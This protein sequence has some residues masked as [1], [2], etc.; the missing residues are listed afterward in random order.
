M[1]QLDT[2]NLRAAR[3]ME[4]GRLVATLRSPTGAHITLKLRCRKAPEKQGGK[5]LGCT[6]AEATILFIEVP[7][8]GWGDRVARVT[9]SRGFQPDAKAD[10][11]RVWAARALLSWLGG[12]PVAEG[13][14][15]MEEERCG[16]CGRA[17]TD[18]VS[19]ERGIGPECYGAMTGSQ[20]QAKI[21]PEA[22]PTEE[23]QVAVARLSDLELQDERAAGERA[24]AEW[25]NGNE[26]QA[27]QG[28]GRDKKGVAFGHGDFRARQQ[29]VADS[30]KAHAPAKQTKDEAREELFANCSQMN[31]LPGE[32]FADIFQG[33]T[34]RT[35]A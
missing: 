35:R 21:K 3:M 8:D 34:P 22:T 7:S 4:G 2:A 11:K 18:P 14:E 28:D 32:S 5:W 9:R 23:L 25:D 19:I 24:E 17:L 10:P 26:R 6:L 16:K 27:P 1:I 30:V 12:F 33:A 31:E 15:I 20:H 13:L 29:V